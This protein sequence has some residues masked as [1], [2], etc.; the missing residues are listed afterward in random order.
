M[1]GDIRTALYFFFGT[2]PLYWQYG[3]V[4]PIVQDL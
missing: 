4:V 2:R 3:A 1:A